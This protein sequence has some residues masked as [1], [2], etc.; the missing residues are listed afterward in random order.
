MVKK[1]KKK[2]HYCNPKFKNSCFF[3]NSDI[4]CHQGEKKQENIQVI[5]MLSYIDHR[6][7][8][9]KLD[10]ETCGH[11]VLR[12][13]EGVAGSAVTVEIVPGNKRKRKRIYK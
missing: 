2:V 6:F 10:D 5:K 7:E 3:H 11:R 1:K 13:R 12:G 8:R 4:F 9:T